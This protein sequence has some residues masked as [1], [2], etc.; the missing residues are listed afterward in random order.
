MK[1]H[2]TKPG[3][4][5]QANGPRVTLDWK[6]VP[7]TQSYTVLIKLGSPTGNKVQKKS[8]LSDS[9]LTTKPLVK[10]QTY[11]WEV[12]AV[13]DAGKTKSDWSSFMVK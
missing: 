6:N 12:A 13:G 9:T 2:L 10:G 8:K 5:S 4:N 11:A 7:C 3:N 1:P